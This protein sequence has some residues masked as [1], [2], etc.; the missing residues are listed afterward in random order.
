MRRTESGELAPQQIPLIV[1]KIE[2]CLERL[3][4][5]TEAVD[6]GM[7]QAQRVFGGVVLGV[8]QPQNK[9]H[10]GRQNRTENADVL[11]LK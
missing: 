4:L 1:T 3:Y 11:G 10:Y 7:K 8:I 2:L 9:R 6:G 5:R